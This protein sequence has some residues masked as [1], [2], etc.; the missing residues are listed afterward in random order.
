MKSIYKLLAIAC[1]ALLSFTT[2]AQVGI[3][4]DNP[5]KSAILELASSDKALLITRVN[6]VI[7]V[8]DPQPGMIV[9]EIANNC[10]KGF[11]QSAWSDCFSTT[12]FGTTSVT[13]DQ[14]SGSE[15][16]E[17]IVP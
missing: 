1:F 17:K 6:D 3:G 15:T 2:Q 16:D 5:Y 4:T 10:F 9:Y 11:E 8:N 13:P 14:D 7:D 12:I